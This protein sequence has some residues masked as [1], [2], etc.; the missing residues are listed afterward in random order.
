MVVNPE[1]MPFI[2][3]GISTSSSGFGKEWIEWHAF[4]SNCLG[5]SSTLILF[6]RSW[7]GVR[8]VSSI[9]SPKQSAS[10]MI[11]ICDMPVVGKSQIVAAVPISLL[12][13]GPSASRNPY[14]YTLWP[15]VSTIKLLAPATH[16]SACESISQRGIRFD[17]LVADMILI[18]SIYRCI[19]LTCMALG[20]EMFTVIESLSIVLVS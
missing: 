11:T 17:M 10:D 14:I 1:M 6:A 19:G 5:T 16:V 15:V 4:G 9:L 2:S 12:G 18:R 3:R 20:V 13:I 7:L 8:S